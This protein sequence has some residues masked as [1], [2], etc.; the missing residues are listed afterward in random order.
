MIQ[1][2]FHRSKCIGCAYCEEVAPQRWKMNP[3]DGKSTLLDSQKKAI[4]FICTTTNDEWESCKQAEELCPV[5]IIKVSE[6]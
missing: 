2:R 1:I 5:N 4:M 6:L 3:A